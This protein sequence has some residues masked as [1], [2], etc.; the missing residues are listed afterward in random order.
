MAKFLR[1]NLKW[2]ETFE[3]QAYEGK[4]P[5]PESIDYRVEDNFV[6][7]PDQQELSE[8]LIDD[9]CEDYEWVVLDYSFE[10]IEHSP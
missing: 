7:G 3:G 5:L 1:V 4:E 9:L 6:F 10:I 2:F 8:G